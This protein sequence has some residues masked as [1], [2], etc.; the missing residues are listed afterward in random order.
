MT[1]ARVALKAKPTAQVPAMI[2]TMPRAR[3]QP[4]C[5]RML[6]ASSVDSSTFDYFSQSSWLIS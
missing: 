4:Q 3:N 2:W 1:E 6:F 5:F